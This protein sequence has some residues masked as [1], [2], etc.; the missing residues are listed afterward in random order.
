MAPAADRFVLWSAAMQHA[1]YGHGGFYHRPE[2][3]RGHFR[4]SVH[5]SSSFAGAV[6]RLLVEVDGALGHPARVD[7]VDVGA[8]RGE[9]LR[10]VL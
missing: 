4:T 10:D 2:G 6:A 9:L 7:L 1:L 8:G 5:A 3:P